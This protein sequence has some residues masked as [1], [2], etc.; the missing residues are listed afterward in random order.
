MIE[1]CIVKGCPRIVYAKPRI[2]SEDEQGRLASVV[3]EL[4]HCQ[5]H[6]ESVTIAG[7]LTDDV[8][9]GIYEAGV[10]AGY[11][12]KRENLRIEWCLADG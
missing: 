4:G 3:M 1:P 12:L 10:S 7:I 2:V 6:M 8:W 11:M 9:N 5:R